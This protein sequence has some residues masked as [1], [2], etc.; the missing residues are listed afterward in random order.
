LGRHRFVDLAVEMCMPS[1]FGPPIG[2]IARRRADEA[3][4]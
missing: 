3:T 4:R 1:G 2:T